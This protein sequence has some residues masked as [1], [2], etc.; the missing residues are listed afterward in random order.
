MINTHNPLCR[1]HTIATIIKLKSIFRERE[2]ERER[3]GQTYRDREG[4]RQRETHTERQRGTKRKIFVHPYLLKPS[5]LLL[6]RSFG[7]VQPHRLVLLLDVECAS[8]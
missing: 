5:L 1:V 8:A 6:H 3:G 7:C 4:E 2:R